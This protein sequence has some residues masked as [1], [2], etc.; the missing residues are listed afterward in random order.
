MSVFGRRKAT[1]PPQ[2]AFSHS[3][4]CKIKAA[5]LG[6]EIPWNEVRPGYWEARASTASRVGTRLTPAMVVGTTR[7]TRRPPA[8]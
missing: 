6:V 3:E 8:T 5:D 1:A 7:T 4:D 2:K